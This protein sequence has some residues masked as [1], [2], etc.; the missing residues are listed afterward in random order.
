MNL[1][2]F[3][4]KIGL[5]ISN[6]T[7]GQIIRTI[8]F[9]F[10]RRFHIYSNVSFDEFIQLF[11]TWAFWEDGLAFDFVMT[12]AGRIHIRFGDQIRFANS[13]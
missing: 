11:L 1:F 12:W 9:V 10:R 13:N 7:F 5:T 8:L 6:V 3:D 2:S 4:M